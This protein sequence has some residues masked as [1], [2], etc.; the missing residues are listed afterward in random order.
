MVILDRTQIEEL[1]DL[2]VAG[3]A[4]EAAYISASRGAVTLPPVGHIMFPEASADCHIKFGHVKGDPSFTVLPNPLRL[5]SRLENFLVKV[6]G[7]PGIEPGVRLREGVTVLT[8]HRYFKRIFVFGPK[9]IEYMHN[10]FGTSLYGALAVRH[11][12]KYR[13]EGRTPDLRCKLRR[14]L[15]CGIKCEFATS[16]PMSALDR[17]SRISATLNLQILGLKRWM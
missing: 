7:D 13:H 8:K 11:E 14:G 17:Q 6:V 10:A 15:L 1:I 9:N 5:A 12:G 3:A 4:I 2:K 16:A